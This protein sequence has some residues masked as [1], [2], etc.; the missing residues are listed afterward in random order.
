MFADGV[1]AKDHFKAE[2]I[3]DQIAALHGLLGVSAL[4][5]I[6]EG[7][8]AREATRLASEIADVSPMFGWRKPNYTDIGE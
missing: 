8:F 2:E 6:P 1:R 4:D 3:D 7:I 5:Q